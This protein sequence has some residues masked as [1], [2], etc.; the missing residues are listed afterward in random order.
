VSDQHG[1]RVLPRNVAATV[2]TAG[3]VLGASACGAMPE[4]PAARSADQHAQRES[5]VLSEVRDHAVPASWAATWV[6]GNGDDTIAALLAQG[7]T[8]RGTLVLRISV[9][10]QTGDLDAQHA[11]QCYRYTLDRYTDAAKRLSTCP[12][13]PALDLPDPPEP[14]LLTAA[15]AARVAAAVTRLPERSP[16]TV[17][18]AVTALFDPACGSWSAR[19]TRPAAPIWW[20]TPA[21]AA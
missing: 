8:F 2:V 16:A 7:D 10:T 5:G 14:D 1:P 4:S 15:S 21:R 12:D 20:S 19:T 3:V 9:T 17:R 13:L 6:T 11:T 18:T